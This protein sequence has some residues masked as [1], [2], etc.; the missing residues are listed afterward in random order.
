MGV[1]KIVYCLFSTLRLSYFKASELFGTTGKINNQNKIFIV[2]PQ[3]QR[4]DDKVEPLI[5]MKDQRSYPTGRKREKN[6]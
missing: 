3:W 1:P 5:L 2:W 4:G 6:N